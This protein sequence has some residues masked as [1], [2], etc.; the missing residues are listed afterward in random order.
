MED[1]PR[2]FIY[3]PID[4]T[5]QVIVEVGNKQGMTFSLEHLPA[6]V[7]FVVKVLNTHADM[8]DVLADIQSKGLPNGSSEEN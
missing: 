4:E 6:L 1:N 3:V 8:I 7:Y 2:K 5:N